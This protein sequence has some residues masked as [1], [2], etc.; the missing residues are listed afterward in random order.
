MKTIAIALTLLIGCPSLAHA[1]DVFF[2]PENIADCRDNSV[3]QWRGPGT[4]VRCVVNPG[5]P[6]NAVMAFASESCPNGWEEYSD[7]DG[8]VLVGAD[9]NLYPLNSTGGAN[10]VTIKMTQMP[11]HSHPIRLTS[12]A[13]DASLRSVWR[14]DMSH[15]GQLEYDWIGRGTGTGIYEVSPDARY[16]HDVFAAMGDG[17]GPFTSAGF[18]GG[19]PDQ[20]EG[21]AEQMDVRMPYLALTFCKKL[22]EVGAIIVP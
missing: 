21:H 18:A 7:A 22:S 19:L 4:A 1:G 16:K 20:V 12:V 17:L 11:R 9:G 8:R 14:G 6:E 13:D 5:V 3:L 2:P 15:D 10:S